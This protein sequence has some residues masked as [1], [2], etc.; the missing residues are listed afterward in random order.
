MLF[1]KSIHKPVQPEDG[2]RISV[3]S[4]HTLSDGKTPDPLITGKSYI[5]WW[6]DLAPRDTLVGAWYR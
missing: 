4:R 3:M 5:E 2:Y 6:K 1:T